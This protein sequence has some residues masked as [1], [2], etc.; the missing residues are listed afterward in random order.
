MQHVSDVPPTIVLHLPCP[1][2]LNALWSHPPGMKRRIRSPE[3]S[4]WLVQAGWE[5]RRQLVGVP[6]ILGA[7]SATVTVPVTSRRDRDSWTKALFDLCQ[8]V[9]AVRND[10]GLRD[11]SVTADERDDVMLALWDLGGPPVAAGRSLPANLSTK[12]RAPTQAERRFAAARMGFGLGSV[13]RQ[14]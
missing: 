10:S 11:Y 7:F 12:P 3:Y 1:P 4:A 8:H 2:S 13:R 9:G 5:A 6:T 14:R